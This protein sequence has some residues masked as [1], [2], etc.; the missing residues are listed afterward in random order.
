MVEANM[1]YNGSEN[2][3]AGNRFALFPAAS[4]GW[5]ASEE[6]FWESG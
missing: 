2:F 3:A 6:K 1:G 5:V 4:V